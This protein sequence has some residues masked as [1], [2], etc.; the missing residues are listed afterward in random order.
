MFIGVEPTL[1]LLLYNSA[2]LALSLDT[3]PIFTP[4]HPSYLSAKVLLYPY[5]Y[6]FN[7][8]GDK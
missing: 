2:D 5:F 7:L 1:L 6:I 4:S 8:R 3:L